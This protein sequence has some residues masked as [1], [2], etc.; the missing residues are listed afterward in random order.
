METIVATA[1][2]SSIG[3]T[4][5][6]FGP[7]LIWWIIRQRW[8]IIYRHRVDN[9]DYYDV[10]D[11]GAWS[12]IVNHQIGSVMAYCNLNMKVT[13]SIQTKL[14]KCWKEKGLNKVD[15]KFMQNGDWV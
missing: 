7:H 1:F 9:M 4:I 14:T 6:V 8:T 10:F 5:G 15:I 3:A 2:G 12:G 13:K 11:Y